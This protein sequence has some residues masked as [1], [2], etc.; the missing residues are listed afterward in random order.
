MP[1]SQS[2]TATRVLIMQTVEGGKVGRIA[3]LPGAIRRRDCL[4]STEAGCTMRL[5]GGAAAISF[6]SSSFVRP[7]GNTS[8][9][10][11]NSVIVSRLMAPACHAATIL[12]SLGGVLFIAISWLP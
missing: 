5:D 1:G 6:F 9:R 2:V 7:S 10:R 4:Y 12:F 8:P 11:N 3:W